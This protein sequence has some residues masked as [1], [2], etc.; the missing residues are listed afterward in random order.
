MEAEKFRGYLAS[1]VAALAVTGGALGAVFVWLHAEDVNP[2]RDLALII[3]VMTG[4]IGA[5]STFLF[6]SD[7]GSRAAHASERATAAGV[8][9]QPTITTS[10]GPPA[11]STIT[12]AGITPDVDPEPTAAAGVEP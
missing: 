10:S 1:I 6:M 12:P 9:S 2:P 7:A 8:A 11:T 4:L 5:G 3:G